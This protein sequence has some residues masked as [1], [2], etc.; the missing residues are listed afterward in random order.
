MAQLHPD[1]AKCPECGERPADD[2]RIEGR[3]GSVGDDWEI[4]VQF[5]C[6]ECGAVLSGYGSIPPEGVSSGGL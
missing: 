1:R 3:I 4:Q 5:E 6:P 2:A